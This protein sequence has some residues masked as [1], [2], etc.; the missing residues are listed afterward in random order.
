MARKREVGR[1]KNV[2]PIESVA[3][4]APV[5]LMNSVRHFQARHDRNT[6]S[7]EIKIAL[8]LHVVES[9]LAALDYDTEFVEDL[10][11]RA[12]DLDE[13]AR[14]TLADRERIRAAAF[15]PTAHDRLAPLIATRAK[16]GK[17]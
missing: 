13:F 11:A 4:R 9:M 6:I 8:E 12:I 3:F 15:Q 14:E 16:E 10:K 2:V 5:S 7:D 1:P 17:P